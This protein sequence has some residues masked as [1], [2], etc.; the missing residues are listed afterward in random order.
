MRL[1]SL[2]SS[3]VAVVTALAFYTFAAW[4]AVNHLYLMRLPMLSYHLVS[5]AVESL[6]A[7]TV[8][9]FVIRALQRK[10]RELEE[11]SRQKDMLTSTL[12]H[13]L[14][15]PLTAV[16]MGLDTV[17]R[18]PNLPGGTREV[19]SIAHRGG[20]QLL[21]MVSDLLDI[22]K[23]EAGQPLIEEQPLSA[24]GFITEGVEAAQQF[25]ARSEIN[26]EVD[27]PADLPDVRGDAKR[28]RRVVMNLVDNAVKFTSSGGR[29]RVSARADD[30]SDRLLVSVSDT[31]LGIPKEFQQ[32]VFD[33]F[34]AADHRRSGG[35]ASTGLGLTFCKMIVEA[36]GGEIGV[37]SEPGQG[38]T[39]TFSIPSV[40]AP[41]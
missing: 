13:D 19:V 21:D 32:R 16:I 28:L 29:V 12:V 2:L 1:R 35:R 9:F 33:K 10:N 23:L 40:E 22:A 31:G 6:A 18:D 7:G 30:T 15:Q 27:L 8:A 5:L 37:E 26:F 3:P 41:E 4:Q 20:A 38:S 14:R 39:F 36:H 17:Q 24:V 25:A 11:L 34:A